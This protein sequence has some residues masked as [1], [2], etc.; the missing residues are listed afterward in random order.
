MILL[1]IITVSSHGDERY[2]SSPP[3][4][5]IDDYTLIRLFDINNRSLLEILDK[6]IGAA[7]KMPNIVELNDR[8]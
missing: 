8:L 7:F 3:G 1:Y 6:I 2:L 4:L 5:R